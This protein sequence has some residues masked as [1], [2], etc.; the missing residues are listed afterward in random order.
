MSEPKVQIANSRLQNGLILA[1]RTNSLRHFGAAPISRVGES[2]G[3]QGEMGQLTN[4]TKH[5]RFAAFEQ[6]TENFSVLPQTNLFV[7]SNNNLAI[8]LLWITE[9]R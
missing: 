9:K 7:F 6:W 8:G 5:T 1:W 4:P 2:P 3:H